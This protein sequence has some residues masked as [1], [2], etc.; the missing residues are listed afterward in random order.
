MREFE[1]NAAIV[2]ILFTVV[3][4]KACLVAIDVSRRTTPE[5]TSLD[6]ELSPDYGS[7]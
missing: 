1:A 5:M 2:N 3:Q 7:G 6:V 4:I